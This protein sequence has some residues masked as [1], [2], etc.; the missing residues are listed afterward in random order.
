MAGLLYLPRFMSIMPR[1]R[2]SDRADTFKVMERR[3]LKA[4]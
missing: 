4:L 1:R 2:L 3:L